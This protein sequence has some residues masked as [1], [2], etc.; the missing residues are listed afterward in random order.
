MRLG[1]KLKEF[2]GRLQTGPFGSQLH[3]YEYVTEGV[4]VI[5]PQQINNGVVETETIARITSR[6]AMQMRR[7]WVDPNDIIFSRRGDFCRSAAIGDRESGWVC[8]TG[9]FRL[10]VSR[11]AI[12]AAWLSH[13]YRHPFIQRQVDANAVGS[14]M[15]SLN[16]AVMER[17]QFTFPPVCEQCEIAR[18]ISAIDTCIRTEKERRNKSLL[19]KLGLMQDLLTGKVRVTVSP[20]EEACQ[21]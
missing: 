8:G 20:S 6:K 2:D 14:T 10:R 9:C 12:D 4:L 11:H 5:M 3:S 1:E 15:P 17:L 16:N 13:L 7:H 21:K 19:I 18:R